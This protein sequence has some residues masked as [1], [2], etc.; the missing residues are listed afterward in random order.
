MKVLCKKTLYW[1]QAGALINDQPEI[2]N[3]PGE[4]IFKAGKEY[5]TFAMPIRKDNGLC[6]IHLV[7][8]GEGCRI[9]IVLSDELH[10][11]S[12]D[13]IFEHFDF[14]SLELNFPQVRNH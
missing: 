1:H 10:Y 9:F 12:A 5:E 11:G 7:A 8:I 2:N 4:L 14:A 3:K 6:Y 13:L